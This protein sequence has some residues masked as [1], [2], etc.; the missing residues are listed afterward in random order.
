MEDPD[1]LTL[2]VLRKLIAIALTK[3]N[4]ADLLDLIYKL[5]IQ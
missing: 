2:K 1:I 3:C 4:D 5:L